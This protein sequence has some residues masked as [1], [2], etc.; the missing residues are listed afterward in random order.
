MNTL[1]LNLHQKC[2]KAA[3]YRVWTY[4]ALIIISNTIKKRVAWT[5]QSITAKS[6]C[7]I[8]Y[9]LKIFRVAQLVVNVSLVQRP[10]PCCSGSRFKTDLWPFAYFSHPI[11]CQIKPRKAQKTSEEFFSTPIKMIL[12][13]WNRLHTIKIFSHIKLLC[14]RISPKLHLWSMRMGPKIS[15]QKTSGKLG[16]N[17]RLLEQREEV[18]KKTNK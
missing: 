4:F 15:W 16:V 9:I 8:I 7:L 10:C 5:L 3:H 12:N 14:F 1:Q 13:N 18:E 2:V 6:L 11:S 17:C